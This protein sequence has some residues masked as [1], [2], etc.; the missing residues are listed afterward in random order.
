MI[1]RCFVHQRY[2]VGYNGRQVTFEVLRL[3]LDDGKLHIEGGQY[4]ACAI[5]QFA[6]NSAPLFILKLQQAR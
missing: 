5:M 3:R 4:L 2:T 6:C 1:M